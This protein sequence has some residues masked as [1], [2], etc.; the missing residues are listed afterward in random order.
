MSNKLDTHLTTLTTSKAAEDIGVLASI[1][2]SSVGRILRNMITVEITRRRNEIEN[3]RN[4]QTQFP[5]GAMS[6]ND[7]PPVRNYKVLGHAFPGKYS[8]CCDGS[9]GEVTVWEIFVETNPE[10]SSIRVEVPTHSE[11]GNL[12]DE[13]LKQKFE[14]IAQAIYSIEGSS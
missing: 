11:A 14:A 4:D 8:M 5:G 10:L 12:V 3:H 2:G 7:P 9:V 6:P 13:E 1:E